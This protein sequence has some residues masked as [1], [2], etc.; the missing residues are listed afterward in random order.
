M[1]PFANLHNET[2]YIEDA[3]GTRLG[4]YK[5]KVASTSA[6]IF[7]ADVSFE[8]GWKLLREMPGNKE[9]VYVITGAHYSSGHAGI[10]PH[11]SLKLRKGSVLP[12]PIPQ[13]Q[14]QTF[15]ISHSQGIQIGDHN[16][17]NIANSLQGLIEKIEMS[18]ASK[19][20]KEEAKST[21]EKLLGS[22]AVAAI[23]GGATGVL[24]KALAGA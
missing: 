24:L 2:V 1:N 23:L 6:T 16:V 8:E 22:K 18:N 15:N 13:V 20:E 17:Q 12:K 3:S 4:P 7:G 5:T 10:P 14:T 21:L 9:E 11:W 19:E